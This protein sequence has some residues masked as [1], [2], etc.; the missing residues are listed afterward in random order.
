MIL[1][2]IQVKKMTV[3]LSSLVLI[4]KTVIKEIRRIIVA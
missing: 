3:L 4:I 1:V 2:V